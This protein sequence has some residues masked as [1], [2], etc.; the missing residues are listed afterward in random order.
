[1]SPKSIGSRKDA[2]QDAEVDW[3]SLPSFCPVS[4]SSRLAARC[5]LGN[6]AKLIEGIGEAFGWTSD[7]EVRRLSFVSRRVTSLLGYPIAQLAR[8][9]FFLDHVPADEREHV[10]RTFADAARDKRDRDVLLPFGSAHG[11]PSVSVHPI[12]LITQVDFFNSLLTG[13]ASE[14]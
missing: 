8:S 4:A 10:R 14:V 2:R 7:T 3:E 11:E 12:L 9:G 5:P 6:Y 13:R 1:M